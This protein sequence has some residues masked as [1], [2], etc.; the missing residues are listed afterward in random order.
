MR[1]TVSILAAAAVAL[2]GTL[3][4]GGPA[5]AATPSPA[6]AIRTPNGS[7]AQN[8]FRGISSRW[9]QESLDVW[10]ATKTLCCSATAG[11][12]PGPHPKG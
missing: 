11:Q 8:D 1:R 7:R 4:A 9:C 2:V 3:A 6:V 10:F 12:A 5:A